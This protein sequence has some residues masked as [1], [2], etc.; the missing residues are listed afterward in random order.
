[1]R[2]LPITLHPSP[3]RNATV[4]FFHCSCS[5]LCVGPCVHVKGFFQPI[6]I[7]TFSCN[8]NC[9]VCLIC[10]VCLFVCCVSHSGLLW[11]MIM[12]KFEAS[13]V[14][15]WRGLSENLAFVVIMHHHC[16]SSKYP[17]LHCQMSR[18]GLTA[19]MCGWNIIL[20]CTVTASSATAILVSCLADSVIP[21]VVI[22]QLG[23]I[24]D[25][26]KQHIQQ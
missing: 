18:H 11:S 12:L 22:G 23:L 17:I 8:F 19:R 20:T 5:V 15:M 1:M 26:Q 4:W 7:V 16:K 21:S 6:Y 9:I 25:I 13:A 10:C 14:A 24:G 2:H 3:L